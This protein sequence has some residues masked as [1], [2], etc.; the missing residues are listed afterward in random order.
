VLVPLL[1][2]DVTPDEFQDGSHLNAQGA[3][4]FTHRLVLDL[5]QK[6]DAN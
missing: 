2:S 4:R 5:L 6:I 1:P 3:A